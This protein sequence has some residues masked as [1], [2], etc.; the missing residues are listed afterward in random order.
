MLENCAVLEEQATRR[1][2]LGVAGRMT[3]MSKSEAP[4]RRQAEA[5]AEEESLKRSVRAANTT[6]DPDDVPIMGGGTN[7]GVLDGLK[8]GGTTNADLKQLIQSISRGRKQQLNRIEE[9][10]DTLLARIPPDRFDKS[11]WED[12]YVKHVEGNE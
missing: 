11:E 6:L 1:K 8:T 3:S 12:A 7:G 2:N 9:K 10:L 4:D 5:Y